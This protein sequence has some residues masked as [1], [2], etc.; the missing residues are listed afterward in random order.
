MARPKNHTA[1]TACQGR[2]IDMKPC[3]AQRERAKNFCVYINS[4]LLQP[5]CVECSKRLRVESRAHEMLELLKMASAESITGGLLTVTEDA[6]ND[7]IS[8]IEGG[9]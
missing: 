4:P 7:L 1:T 3:E 8:E 6:I 2:R 9:Q 5:E